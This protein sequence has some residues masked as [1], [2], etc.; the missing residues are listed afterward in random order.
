MI[1]FSRDTLYINSLPYTQTFT[2]VHECI[3]MSCMMCFA[4]LNVSHLK[5]KVKPI[6]CKYFYHIYHLTFSPF[7]S[8]L[9]DTYLLSC[10]L[11]EKIRTTFISGSSDILFVCYLLNC[12]LPLGSCLL[13]RHESGID[14]TPE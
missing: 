4:K 3:L 12:L 5:M 2:Q 14:L 10:E 13:H 6:S 1:G 9:F 8:Y 11:D 7:P